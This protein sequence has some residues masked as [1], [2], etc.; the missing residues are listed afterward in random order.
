MKIENYKILG[1]IPARG[2]SKGVIRK[3]IRLVADK[4][5]IHW[6]IAEAKQSKLL[7]HYYVT[8]D[9]DE[10]AE[11]ATSCGAQVIDRPSELAQDKT[12]MIPVLQHLCQEAE[13]LNGITYDYILL[14]QPTAPMRTST[15]IDKAIELFHSTNNAH[16]LVSVYQV[17]DCHPSRMYRVNNDKLEKI[18]S[19]PQGSLRQDLE[20]IFHRN[21]AIYLCDRE[22]LMFD[23]RLTCESPIPFIMPK[24]RSANID[25]EQDLAIADF[26][27]SQFV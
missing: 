7:S 21:G 15:D 22:L 10:I 23:G 27:M 11:V 2:G 16:S 1:I 14:M 20:P 26:L 17:D 18:Y 5:L 8:T 3:N 19:E 9:D 25:D 6:S 12:P 13:L 4:P 24:T